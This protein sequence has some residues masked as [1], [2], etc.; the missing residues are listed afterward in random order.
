MQWLTNQDQHWFWDTDY[1]SGNPQQLLSPYTGVASRKVPEFWQAPYSGVNVG[2]DLLQCASG[3]S[4][5]I[6]P[7]RLVPPAS[8]WCDG[9][10]RLLV[11]NCTSGKCDASMPNG[12][13]SIPGLTLSLNG[14]A[15][16]PTS[17][18]S[19]LY[20]SPIPSTFE[21]LYLGFNVPA[22]V[23]HAST[24]PQALHLS[25]SPASAAAPHRS[26]DRGTSAVSVA[27][28]PGRSAGGGRWHLVSVD[29]ML[30]VRES[31]CAPAEHEPDP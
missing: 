13:P 4:S 28:Q 27:D 20:H 18:T 7:L 22:A 11:Q 12:R 8:K 16:P 23:L 31:E 21:H 6:L 15:L 25:L 24:Q 14:H 30:P 26:A 9:R 17:N 2:I 1:N 3:G 29:L 5:C 10:L 19:R